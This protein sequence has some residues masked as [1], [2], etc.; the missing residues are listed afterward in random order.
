VEAAAVIFLAAGEAFLAAGA[1]AFPAAGEVS[2]GAAHG[3]FLVASA[4]TE[5][6]ADIEA[7]ITTVVA[8]MDTVTTPVSMCTAAMVITAAPIA[9]RPATMTNGEI[10]FPLVAAVTVIS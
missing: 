6:N 1:E 4:D 2:L 3:A 9:A 10:G 7:V 5:A 8:A